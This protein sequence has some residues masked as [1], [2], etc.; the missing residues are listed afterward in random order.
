ML[1]QQTGEII[2]FKPKIEKKGNELLE[3]WFHTLLNPKTNFEILELNYKTKPIIILKIDSAKR[4]P[5]KF[6][7]VGY[8]RMGS[9]KKNLADY[10]QKERKIWEIT[11]GDY[12]EKGVALKDVDE[13]VVI[14]LLDYPSYFKLTDSKLPSSKDGIISKFVEEKMIV[15]KGSNR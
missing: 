1:K 6:K 12:F 14:K 9:Y 2:K 8:I 7:G 13:D 15:K 5:T 11:S 4:M 10:P 3:S